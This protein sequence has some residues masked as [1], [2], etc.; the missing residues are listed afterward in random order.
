MDLKKKKRSV[1]HKFVDRE[2]LTFPK[3]LRVNI[4]EIASLREML[5][6]G[7]PGPLAGPVNELVKHFPE[8]QTPDQ[9]PQK[10][11]FTGKIF[12]TLVEI[13]S[14]FTFCLKS[15]LFLGCWRS[16]AK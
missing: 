7:N 15:I 8:K 14:Y 2:K 3:F 13:F 16:L 5:S 6:F 9:T 11:D 10:T 12:Q 4:P 1:L